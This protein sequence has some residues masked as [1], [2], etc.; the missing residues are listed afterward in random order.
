MQA[1]FVTSDVT[2]VPSLPA[3]PCGEALVGAFRDQEHVPGEAEAPGCPHP[4]FP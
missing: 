1:H 4:P 2:F 3:L